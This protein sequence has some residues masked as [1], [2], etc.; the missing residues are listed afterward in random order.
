MYSGCPSMVFDPV[1]LTP[2]G[3]NAS[4]K[5]HMDGKNMPIY[6]LINLSQISVTV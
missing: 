1:S 2:Y 6:P 3:E 4:P 5:T